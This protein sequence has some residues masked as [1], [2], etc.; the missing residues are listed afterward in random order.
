MRQNSSYL[1]SGYILLLIGL[2][3][4]AFDLALVFVVYWEESC[5]VIDYM[6][7]KDV[8][9]TVECDSYPFAKLRVMS[10]LAIFLGILFMGYT[11]AYKLLQRWRT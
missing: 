2:G 11:I 4:I 6:L 8:L 3:G 9:R 10:Y 7:L 1:K 5:H